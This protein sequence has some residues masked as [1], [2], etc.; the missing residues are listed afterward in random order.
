MERRDI[1]YALAYIFSFLYIAIIGILFSVY[2]DQMQKVEVVAINVKSD[3]DIIVT[4]QGSKSTTSLKELNIKSPKVGVKPISGKLDTQTD[5]PYSVSED[6]DSEG[7]YAK[8]QVI[9]DQSYNITLEDVEGVPESEL[10]NVMVVISNGGENPLS[11]ADLG[12]VLLSIE[13]PQKIQKF[14]IF[15][16]LDAHSSKE[17]IGSKI[18]ISISFNKI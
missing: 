8:F 5:I 2:V 11:L 12:A 7:A 6:I 3:E 10:R 1:G 18:K 13:N 4:N 9:A 15:I 14:T 17:I 16:W